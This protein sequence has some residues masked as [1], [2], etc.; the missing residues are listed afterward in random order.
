[1]K[2]LFSLDCPILRDI[3]D[4]KELPVQNSFVL[5]VESEASKTS[6]NN[7]R[8]NIF[9]KEKLNTTFRPLHRA[10]FIR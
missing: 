4:W 7:K 9:I 10:D 6:T 1:M 8:R 5:L 3:F 2:I